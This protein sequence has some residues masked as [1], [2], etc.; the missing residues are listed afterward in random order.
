MIG[1]RLSSPPRGRHG[2]GLHHHHHHATFDLVATPGFGSSSPAAAATAC[3]ALIAWA[4]AHSVLR[5]LPLGAGFM[6]GVYV[7][8]R[9]TTSR[10]C[11]TLRFADEVEDDEALVALQLSCVYRPALS[12][13]SQ[14]NGERTDRAL[15]G[16]R[17]CVDALMGESSA[18]M[19]VAGD[20]GMCRLGNEV[21]PAGG[22]D[23]GCVGY[24]L[25]GSEA[26][27]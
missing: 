14:S 6:R 21:G 11:R 4:L 23:M 2:H 15:K 25:L 17:A 8:V 13:A 20:G 26:A 12:A 27:D 16:E 1:T 3:A 9:V 7:T 10:M 18:G 22:A 19:P 5:L 24:G